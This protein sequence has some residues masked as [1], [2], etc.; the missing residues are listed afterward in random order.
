MS[1][2]MEQLRASDFVILTGEAK[3]KAYK[4]AKIDSRCTLMNNPAF[5]AD[6]EA[7]GTKVVAITK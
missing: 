6:L 1:K 5:L 3:G 4:F 2:A 7:E